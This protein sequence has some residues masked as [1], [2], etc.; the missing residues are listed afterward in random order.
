LRVGEQGRMVIPAEVRKELGIEVGTEL[1]A[2]IENARLVLETRAAILARLQSQFSQVS[3]SMADELLA[4]RKSQSLQ[5]V[6]ITTDKSWANVSNIQTQ[7][8]R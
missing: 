1:I 7:I 3:E 2:T 4:E 8:I 5:A 6:A